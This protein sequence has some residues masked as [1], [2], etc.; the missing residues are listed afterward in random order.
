MFLVSG[1]EGRPA[2]PLW[3]KDLEP[4]FEIFIAEYNIIHMRALKFLGAY[5]ASASCQA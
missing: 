1:I 3:S 4:R 2:G 5:P